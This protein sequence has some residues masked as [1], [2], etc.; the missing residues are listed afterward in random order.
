MVV[1]DELDER[2]RVGGMALPRKA[3]A[4]TEKV[5]RIQ[6]EGVD[7][8]RHSATIIAFASRPVGFLQ[9][10]ARAIHVEDTRRVARD[11]AHAFEA[12]VGKLGLADPAALA[13]MGGVQGALLG[14]TLAPRVARII[15]WIGVEELVE[16]STAWVST[17]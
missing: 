16:V 14:A 11:E 4:P 15:L 9:N 1:V 8:G 10:F 5:E 3:Q 17:A 7:L 6:I 13:G 12:A 2:H